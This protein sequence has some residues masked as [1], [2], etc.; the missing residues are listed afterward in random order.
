MDRDLGQPSPVREPVTIDGMLAFARARLE[1]LDAVAAAHALQS[2]AVLID[3]RT[4]E[5]RAEDGEIPGAIAIPLN[6][7]EW[8]ADPTTAAYDP[9]LG[10]AATLLIALC[11]QGYC[12][13]LAAARLQD[14]GR[15]ATDVIGGFEAWWAAGLPTT[16]PSRGLRSSHDRAQRLHG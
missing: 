5:Q 7:L 3:V 4:S 15:E 16:P 6:V 10:G 8:R 13:S 9:R 2:D 1:R 12:S 14:L 11:A